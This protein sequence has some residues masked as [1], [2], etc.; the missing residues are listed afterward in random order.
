[1]GS[2]RSA[3]RRPRRTRNSSTREFA[4]TF[5]PRH[6]IILMMPFV[7]VS[8]L[9]AAGTQDGTMESL[10][11]KL[12]SDDPEVRTGA[13]AELLA[14]WPRWKVQDLT[15]LDEAAQDAD[16]ELSGRA[17]EARSRI[18]IRRALGENLFSR[19]PKADDAFFG[20]D[21]AAKLA[22]LGEA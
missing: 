15:K 7:I 4:V 18:R 12:R 17:Q 16:P 21:D 11:R 2:P 5:L 13:A 1:P 22:V 10:L 19:I 3:A 9:L 8:L 6:V 14:A 20:G